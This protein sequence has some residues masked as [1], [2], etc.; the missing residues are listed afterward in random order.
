MVLTGEQI[1]KIEENKARAKARRAQV[2]AEAKVLE[3]KKAKGMICEICKEMPD[4][5]E[6]SETLKETF[7][8]IVCRKCQMTNED[9]QIINKNTVKTEYLL[10]EDTIGIMKHKTRDNPHRPGWA[11][12]KL[13]LRKHARE[14]AIYRWGTLEALDKGTR[15]LK[16][17]DPPLRIIVLLYMIC[18][19]LHRHINPH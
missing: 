10:T 9:Y 5:E 12:M 19:P 18:L 2:E 16:I 15:R 8:V 7:E 4:A 13:F 11:P 6:I 17:E 3:E 1:E 14:E